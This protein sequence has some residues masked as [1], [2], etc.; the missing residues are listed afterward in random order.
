MTSTPAHLRHHLQLFGMACMWGSTWS[1]GRVV[2]Q[3]MPPLTAASVRIAIACAALL[4]APATFNQPREDV[5]AHRIKGVH[6]T[7]EGGLIR[8]HH[9]YQFTRER[10]GRVVADRTN[11]IA[12]VLVAVQTHQGGGAARNQ[13]LLA[14]F[15]ANGVFF[16]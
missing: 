14:V 7:K 11:E 9:I 10:A 1:M 2:V 5:I 4:L 15:E 3:V 8:R 6:I 13:I 12:N 16:T